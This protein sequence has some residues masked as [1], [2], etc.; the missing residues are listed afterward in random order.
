MLIS[1]CGERGLAGDAQQHHVWPSPD[2]PTGSGPRVRGVRHHVSSGGSTVCCHLQGDHRPQDQ[3]GCA[4]VRKK[5]NIVIESMYEKRLL[6][7]LTHVVIQ[8]LCSYKHWLIHS[9]VHSHSHSYTLYLSPQFNPKCRLSPTL[10][11]TEMQQPRYNQCRSL[12]HPRS[13]CIS[14]QFQVFTL[15]PPPVYQNKKETAITPGLMKYAFTLL[16]FDCS[17][18]YA[19]GSSHFRGFTCFLPPVF[20]F[21]FTSFELF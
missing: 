17:P 12:L 2:G 6:W 5:Q 8:S 4:R 19:L 18:L 1:G 16:R 11:L 9:Y 3:R 20:F 14:N 7:W 15:I 13:D 21:F 10:T